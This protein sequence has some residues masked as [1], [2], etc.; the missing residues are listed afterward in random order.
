EKYSKTVF[1]IR[2]I[3][4]ETG[5]NHRLCAGREQYT[6]Y[7]ADW[8]G[9]INLFPGAGAQILRTHAGDLPADLPDAGPSGIV[10][11]PGHSCSLPELHTEEEGNRFTDGKPRARRLAV[12]LRCPGAF[13]Q[14]RVQE[15]DQAT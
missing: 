15:S 6:G 12:P 14:R 2:Y 3:Q 13:Q 11:P 8:F 1:W 4:T 7:T 10:E 9:E 5:R